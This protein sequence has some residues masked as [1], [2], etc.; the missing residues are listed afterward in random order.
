MSTIGYNAGH[1]VNMTLE[2][3]AFRHMIELITTTTK[4]DARK[5]VKEE[6]RLLLQQIIKFTPPFGEQYLTSTGKT[7][8]PHGKT[9][10]RQA[11]DRDI[12]RALNPMLEEDWRSPRI[13]EVIRNRDTKAMMAILDNM[14]YTKSK[15]MTEWAGDFRSQHLKVRDN[16]G[17][18]RK[19]SNVF[20][21]DGK[22]TLNYIK[23]VQKRVGMAKGSW[24]KALSLA[25]GTPAPWTI[26]ALAESSKNIHK[27]LD[28][29]NDPVNPSL[30]V[31]SAARGVKGND[32]LAHHVKGAF[33]VRALS[34]V[35]KLS[36]ML[37]QPGKT[38]YYK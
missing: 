10:G 13:K 15:G 34:M 11:V 2:A 8:R 25:G 22:G 12:R 36:R 16:Y 1:P 37:N 19:K 14:K 26:K 20:T 27:E 28:H 31:V 3:D 23:K 33:R 6:A 24:G 21:F 30:T 38:N 4:T 7:R 32:R 5:V 18:V 35:S 9:I 17:R 29:M